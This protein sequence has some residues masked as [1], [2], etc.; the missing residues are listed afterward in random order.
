MVPAVRLL[1]GGELRAAFRREPA[2]PHRAHRAQALLR[3]GRPGHGG[4][5]RR[6]Q[7]HPQRQD[8]R[9]RLEPRT[10]TLPHVL[11]RGGEHRRGHAQ[12]RPNADRRRAD[13][14][15]DAQREPP[16]FGRGAP[17]R[18]TRPPAPGQAQRVLMGC[19]RARSGLTS[20]DLIC[21]SSLDFKP[22]GAGSCFKSEDAWCPGALDQPLRQRAVRPLPGRHHRP[23]HPAR[24]VDPRAGHGQVEGRGV[25][26]EAHRVDGQG[27]HR[28]ADERGQEGYDF[29][30]PAL[31]AQVLQGGGRG[32]CST[33]CRTRT[34]AST[35]TRASST[36]TPP[37]APS[38]TTSDA[39]RVHGA[40][41]L[42]EADALD[43][44]SARG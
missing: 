8:A 29:R 20:K 5:R 39:D 16:A 35:S 23:A 40:A 25:R 15:E 43:Y 10:R 42:I 38:S 14:L 3:G 13:A 30:N 22:D 37:R 41:Q 36:P 28:R 34:S 44:A 33:T 18:H 4:L 19:R 2:H 7:P 9:G 12:A 31:G 1:R 32:P 27:D 6:V 21:P 24:R 11:G 17:G 26:E